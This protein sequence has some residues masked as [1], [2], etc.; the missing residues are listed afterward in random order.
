[1]RQ[2]LT[3]PSAVLCLSLCLTVTPGFADI[4]RYTDE[5]GTVVLSRQGVPPQYIDN[6]YQV[7]NDAGRLIKDVPRALTPEEIAKQQT[8]NKR[9]ELDACLLRL[10]STQ[11]DI[12]R[13]KQS[14]LREF[15]NLIEN[16]QKQLSPVSEKLA[17]LYEKLTVIRQDRQAAD[18]AQLSLDINRLKTEQRR[19]QSLIVS[20]R[21]QRRQAEAEFDKE[22]A[23][24]SELLGLSS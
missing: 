13:A 16:T 15:D 7:L 8:E 24:L 20:Y 23:R 21:E 4:Y 5:R 14:K 11:N 9:R 12:I 2:I 1:M 3:L 18:D 10:Y 22:Q 6:G 17:Y 19:L